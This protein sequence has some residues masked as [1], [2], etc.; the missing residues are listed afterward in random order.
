MNF[1]I[2]LFLF[3]GCIHFGQAQSFDLI[4]IGVYGGGEE[5]N[6]SAYLISEKDKNEFL[7]L[8]AGTLRSGID[9]AI[10]KGNFNIENIEVIRNYIKGYFISH[11]HLDHL[12]GLIIN[13]PDDSKKNIYGTSA[14]ID[15]LKNRYFTNDAWINFANEGDQPQ[16]GK[17]TYKR[18]D[19]ADGFPI[20]QTQLKGQIFSLSHVNPQKSSAIVVTNPQ[21]EAVLYL[22]DTGADRIEKSDLLHQLWQGVAPILK[23]NKLKAILI[24]TSFDN[25]R[26]EKLLFGHLTP[27]LLTE[28]LQNL[29]KISNKKDLKGLK[30]IITHLKPGGNQI[31]KIKSELE[32][33]N[34]LQVNYIFPV[35]GE[36]ISL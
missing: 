11:G 14:T 18:M 30:V 28:E 33:Y 2:Y 34:P 6:L 9:K 12:S 22:G 35:Q 8:D 15:V 25:Q 23:N 24:E 10:E 4:P 32:A 1:R 17:Y 16:L 20:D 27:K 36:K 5:N 3:L 29:S 7:C 26:D 31:E 21:G 13:S 19:A